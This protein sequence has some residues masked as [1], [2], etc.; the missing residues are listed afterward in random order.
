MVEAGIAGNHGTVHA[1]LLWA[2]VAMRSK[3]MVAI[4]LLIASATVVRS[5]PLQYVCFGEHTADLQY[6]S[7]K[8]A[9][10]DQTLAHH[11]YV[12]RQLTKADHD[13]QSGKWWAVF[14]K[15]PGANW[16]FFEFGNID[17][18]PLAVCEDTSSDL[19]QDVACDRII[20]DGAFNKVTRRFEISFRGSYVTQGF[21]EQLRLENPEA[22]EVLLAQGKAVDPSKPDDLFIE[23]GECKPGPAF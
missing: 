15:H 3:V 19:G 16:A 1:R 8:R 18:T 11:K 22:Y 13:S 2:D 5:D 21:W 12:F 9:W 10:S 23:I 20:D 7:E 14:D 6:D 4:A 17:P